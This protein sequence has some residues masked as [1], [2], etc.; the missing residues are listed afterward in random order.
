MKDKPEF[1]DVDY[2]IWTEMCQTTLYNCHYILESVKILL[3]TNIQENKEILYDHPFVAAGLYT[4][5]VEEYGK[6]LLL[7]SISEQDG[8]YNIIYK[9]EFRWHSEKFKKAFSIIPEECKLVHKGVFD[10]AI[11]DSNIFDT[12]EIADFETRLNI[13]YSDFDENQQIQ[14]L[15]TVDA[16]SLQTALT[17]F[18]DIVEDELEK[19]TIHHFQEKNH[20]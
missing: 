2:K 8:K 20:A 17:K 4:Y 18:T 16:K 19:F 6:F 1:L 3:D 11:V 10:D 5:A 15:P 13:F 7:N 9:N 12:D 14:K